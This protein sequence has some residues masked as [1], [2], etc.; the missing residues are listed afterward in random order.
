M[1]GNETHPEAC[2]YEISLGTKR[3]SYL[4]K[5]ATQLESEALLIFQQPHVK[6]EVNGVEPSKLKKKIFLILNSMSSYFI[7]QAE[8]QNKNIFTHSE[9]QK[10]YPPRDL[11]Q[12]T[13]RKYTPLNEEIKQE[14]IYRLHETGDST[15]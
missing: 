12:K 6:L 15:Q 2:H 3:K 11:F 4:K 9:S 5:L 8:K 1:N 13:A 7:N 10:I 14:R